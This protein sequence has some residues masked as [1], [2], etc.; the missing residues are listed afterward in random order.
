MDWLRECD[1]LMA[2]CAE[3]VDGIV[4]RVIVV[5][6]DYEPN[7]EQFATQWAGVVEF[8]N[9]LHTTQTFEASMQE[10]VIPTMLMKTFLLSLNLFHLG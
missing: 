6:N 8:G 2:H 4:T 5:S 10:L 9:K 7:V 3:I 1:F